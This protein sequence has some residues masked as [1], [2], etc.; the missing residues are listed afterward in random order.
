MCIRDSNMCVLFRELGIARMA[1]TG[2]VE[3]YFIPECSGAIEHA[4]T[5]DS[6]EIHKATT[7]VISQTQALIIAFDDIIKA[8]A[9]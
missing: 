2:K 1:L 7:L 4:G 8:I 5:W 6:Q 9:Q 3:T